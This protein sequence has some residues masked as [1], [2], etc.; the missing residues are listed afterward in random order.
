MIV[1]FALQNH[2]DMATHWVS[3]N[4]FFI[5][6]QLT[7]RID[8]HSLLCGALRMLDWLHQTLTSTVTHAV[9][10]A[11]MPIY[12]FLVDGS[13]R[14]H[15]IYVLSGLIIAAYAYRKHST[16]MSFETTLLDKQVWLSKSAINDYIIVVVT[17]VLRLTVLSG[18]ALNWKAVSA[19]VVTVLESAGVSGLTHDANVMALG[20]ALTVT[21]FLVDDFLRWYAHYT[22]HRIPELWEFHKVHHSAE[23]LNFATAERHHPVE[24]IMT[25]SLLFLG[26]GAVNGIF[27][28]LFGEK[29]TVTTVAGAN[30]FLF[31]FNVCGGVLRHSPFWVSFGP[32]IEKWIIS[33]AMHQIHHS[34]KPEH[35]D[36]NLGGALS[37]WDRMAGT[38]HI[39]RGREIEGF[40]IGEETQDFRSLQVIFLRPFTAAGS[41]LR[42]RFSHATDEQATQPAAHQASTHSIT[43]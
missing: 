37:V 36:K 16:A 41:L 39:P 43:A 14:Y 42:K 9:I 12:D 31:A 22:F 24:T 20:V 5:A 13:S 33:P 23:V 29:L 21:L 38:L 30:V 28:G 35:F 34:N 26:Y 18:L 40:G 10:G 3:V 19:T 6:I 7:S 15:W 25:S 4:S 8:F 27:I 2:A 17:P 1:G 32:R 11:L